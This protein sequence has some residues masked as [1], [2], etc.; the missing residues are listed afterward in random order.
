VVL[1]LIYMLLHMPISGV[2]CHLAITLHPA[3]QTMSRRKDLI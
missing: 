1:M 3:S 2:A